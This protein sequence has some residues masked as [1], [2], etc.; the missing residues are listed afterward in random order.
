MAG[1][2]LEPLFCSGFEEGGTA[3]P[4]LHQKPDASIP[5]GNSSAHQSGC[6][7]LNVGG[8]TADTSYT[9]SLNPMTT[10]TQVQDDQAFEVL[11]D[12][13][14][15]SVNGGVAPAVGLIKFFHLL[16]FIFR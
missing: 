12:E 14:L 16:A 2:L 15:E 3:S 1:F 9:Q 5:D 13:E 7:L 6:D 11:T 10:L 8:N 4:P